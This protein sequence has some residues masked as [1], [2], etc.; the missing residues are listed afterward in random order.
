MEIRAK[1]VL[2]S[3]NLLEEEGIDLSKFSDWLRMRR[4]AA[5][6]LRFANNARPAKYDLPKR[7]GCI[8]VAELEVAEHFILKDVQQNAF[9]EEISHLERGK[10]VPS[11]SVLSPLSPYVDSSGMLRVGGRLKNVSIAPDVGT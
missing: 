2:V 5:W 10:A 4:V 8:A 3:L 1:P 6:M 9:E 7:K 11:T